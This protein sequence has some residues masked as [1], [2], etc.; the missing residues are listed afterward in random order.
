M[1]AGLTPREQAER[2]LALMTAGVLGEKTGPPR[3]DRETVELLFDVVRRSVN[4]DHG[5]A[6]PVTLQWDFPDAPA[7]RVRIDN[8]STAAEPGLDPAA[9]L[10]AALPLRGLGRRDRPGAAIRGGCSSP[11][12]CGRAAA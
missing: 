9:D 8:G 7:W 6:Q 1:P 3:R 12:G 4:P 10:D 11:A 2:G 5:L